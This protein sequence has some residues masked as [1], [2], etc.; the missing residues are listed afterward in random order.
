MDEK[1]VKRKNYYSFN[2]HNIFLLEI[3][4][5]ITYVIKLKIIK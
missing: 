5:C 4:V 2:Y 1:K 3:V